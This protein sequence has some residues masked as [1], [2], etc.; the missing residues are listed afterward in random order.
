MSIVQ[1]WSLPGQPPGGTANQVVLQGD[2]FSSPKSM[3]IINATDVGDNTGGALTWTVQMD[4]RYISVVS[5]AAFVVTGGAALVE[6]RMTVEGRTGHI[7][8]ATGNSA[9]TDIIAGIASRAWVPPPLIDVRQLIWQID[10]TDA[11]AYTV[12][13]TI[14]NFDREAMNRVPLSIIYASLPRVGATT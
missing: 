10:N 2:G 9:F 3:F 13:A 5:M 12:T 4:P 6:H 1:A 8:F 7:N 14:F 11:L